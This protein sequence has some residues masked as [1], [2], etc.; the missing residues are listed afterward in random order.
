M[1]GRIAPVLWAAGNAAGQAVWAA[2]QMA[3]LIL[4][5]HL[6]LQ[7]LIGIYAVGLGVFAVATLFL[8]FNLR[9]AVSTDREQAIGFGAAISARTIA[10]L[11][12]LPLAIGSM[13]LMQPSPEELLVASLL[14]A[15]RLPDQLSD[16][17][18]G[19]YLR[20]SR[21][22]P[23][24]RSFLVRG[25]V[26]LAVV[27][28][29]WW[30][31]WSVGFLAV[32]M[33]VSVSIAAVA[34]DVVPEWLRQDGRAGGS[35]IRQLLRETWA[36]SPY[37]ALDSLHLNSL[38]FALVMVTGPAF[39]GL[40]AIAQ[41]LFT[42]FQIAMNALGFGYLESARR[43]HDSGGGASLQR[44]VR[45]G[46]LLGALLG[47]G[48]VATCLFLPDPLVRL[49]FADKAGDAEGPLIVAAVAIGLSPLCGFLSLCVVTGGNRASYLAAPLAG[50]AAVWIG[51]P[52]L[53]LS[54][55]V[56]PAI[57][58]YEAALAVAWLFAGSY[59][60]RLALSLRAL[61]ATVRDGEA[62]AAAARGGA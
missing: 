49:L 4:L 7:R 39:T 11:V 54:G 9:V 8:G 36:I 34:V 2:G 51:T 52:L 15:A 12:A 44:H 14:V 59:V 16:V 31:G 21:R 61:R 42:P 62:A 19:F 26:A 41:V 28:L 13:A 43:A 60:V 3:V 10:C 24:S 48:F 27:G 25:L 20:G 50:L 22:A 58:P 53:L 18:I 29:A 46:L 57:G 55:F 40:V 23:I 1:R 38:R 32:A 37:P 45:L 33:V 5:S 30:L 35:S 17:I 6:G 47:A 56:E